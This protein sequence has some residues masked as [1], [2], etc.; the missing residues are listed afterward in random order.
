[1]LIREARTQ[2]GLTVAQLA[3][4]VGVTAT[5]LR[6]LERGVKKNPSM[7]VVAGMADVLGK[8]VSYF[9]GKQE[10]A[11]TLISALPADVSGYVRE[12]ILEP[13]GTSQESVETWSDTQ[14]MEAFVHYLRTLKKRTESEE[15]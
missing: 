13:F 10:E 3:E 12:K 9:F 15:K 14:V 8:P 1:M 2:S 4:A 5:Y 6:E 11:G 7:Q